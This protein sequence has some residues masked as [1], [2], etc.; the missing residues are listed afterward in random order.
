MQ[1]VQDASSSGVETE[2]VRTKLEAA[3]KAGQQGKLRI[4]DLEHQVHHSRPLVTSEN[5]SLLPC[6]LVATPFGYRAPL[7]PCPLVTATFSYHAP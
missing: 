2:H 1:A 7:L 3:V 6:P 4:T 5:P